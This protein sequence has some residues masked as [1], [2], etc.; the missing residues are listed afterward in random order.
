MTDSD[1]CRDG[2]TAPLSRLPWGTHACLIYQHRHDLIDTL[3]PYFQSGL[4]QNARCIWITTEPL[5][6]GSARRVLA[7]SVK[8]LDRRLERRQV[9]ILDARDWYFREGTFS[10]IA[11]AENCIKNGLEAQEG[12]YEGL[13][14]TGN[15]SWLTAAEWDAFMGYEATINR[16]LKDN[17]INAV[18]AYPLGACGACELL[19]IAST[20]QTAVIR[21]NGAWRQIDT[22]ETPASLEE[23]KKKALDQIEANIEQFATL[24]D[25]I[26]HP[27]QVLMAMADLAE[28]EQSDAIRQQARNIDA[29]VRQL[30]AGWAGSRAIR[31]YLMN[32]DLAGAL[33]APVTEPGPCPRPGEYPGSRR[34]S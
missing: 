5:Q 20:H 34:S 30:D 19:E 15:L 21:Q 16:S 22:G 13:F 24:A 33:P 14:I 2:T 31:E 32:H 27:L 9:E 10:G 29:V 6:A 28:N 12:G 25:R 11:A 7:R 18:C 4:E 3:V 23:Q 1:C 8:D 17:R 26:R